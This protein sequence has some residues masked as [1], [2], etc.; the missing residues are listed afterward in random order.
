MDTTPLIATTIQSPIETNRVSN[1]SLTRTHASH[2]T[3]SNEDPAA[4]SVEISSSSD[5]TDLLLG[6]LDKV[7]EYT[8]MENDLRYKA[9]LDPSSVNEHEILLASAKAS[10][11]VSIT[12]SVIDRALEAYRSIIS[13]R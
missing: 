3:G 1:F 11:S 9:M 4:S 10:M 5:F 7:S 8:E 12:K 6:S 2:L 13:L